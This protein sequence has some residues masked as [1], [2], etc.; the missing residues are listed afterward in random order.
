M[1]EVTGAEEVAS[2][3]RGLGAALA[4]GDAIADA[5]RAQAKAHAPSR[6][7]L[8]IPAIA[9]G[10]ATVNYSGVIYD[11]G[12]QNTNNPALEAAATAA[13]EDHINDAIQRAGLT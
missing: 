4:V 9:Y 10:G 3:L 2:D 13:V 11:E 8:T 6:A 7:R 12:F 5:A 1:S